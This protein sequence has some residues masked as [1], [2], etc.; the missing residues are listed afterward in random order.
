MVLNHYTWTGMVGCRS[1]NFVDLGRCLPCC[2][3]TRHQRLVWIL[4][5]I[6]ADTSPIKH[7]VTFGSV[8]LICLSV[9]LVASLFRRA[10]GN[11]PTLHPLPKIHFGFWW[12]LPSSILGQSHCNSLRNAVI[13]GNGV[14]VK[15]VGFGAGRG[16]PV[17]CRLSST[18]NIFISALQSGIIFKSIFSRSSES[19]PD[20]STPVGAAPTLQ[21]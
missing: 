9:A 14:S 2:S 13:N 21:M 12:Q 1:L 3:A 6:T 17:A 10:V 16:C 20:S 18:K 11:S 19:A 8:C 5:D 15:R 7:L 4:S